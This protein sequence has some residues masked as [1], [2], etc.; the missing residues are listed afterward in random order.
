[1][2]RFLHDEQPEPGIV[3][4][5]KKALSKLGIIQ[6]VCGVLALI[7]FLLEWKVFGF[8]I[9]LYIIG[10]VHLFGGGWCVI[11]VYRRGKITPGL[12][13]VATVVALC[14]AIIAGVQMVFSI[15]IL[16]RATIYAEY[17]RS[18]DSHVTD[19]IDS[20]VTIEAFAV[21]VLL[22]GAVSLAAAIAQAL[23]CIRELN[24][25]ADTFSV[26]VRYLTKVP[27]P[28]SASTTNLVGGDYDFDEPVASI[29]I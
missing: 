9:P 4:Y 25:K 27:E 7:A 15:V 21:V 29:Q 3:G 12:F 14:S 20:P 24:N 10:V 17:Y 22:I 1:M 13:V 18:L 16:C 19:A 2:V 8:L 5:Y 28:K 11:E 23:I 26:P 6:M